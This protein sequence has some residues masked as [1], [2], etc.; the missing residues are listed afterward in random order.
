MARYFDGASSISL[1]DNAALSF[2]SDVDND[3]PFSFAFWILYKP[4]A[5]SGSQF[6]VGW[7]DWQAT[8]S[9]NIITY[10]AAGASPGRL[11]I[12]IE[13]GN[14]SNCSL[15]TNTAMNDGAWHH[16]AI[17]FDGTVLRAYIDGTVET[18]TTTKADLDRVDVGGTWHFGVRSLGYNYLQTT[19]MAEWAKWDVALTAEEIARLVAGVRAVDIGRRPAWY[20]PMCGGLHEEIG[21]V[22]ATNSGTDESE[23]PPRAVCPDRP[24]VSRAMYALIAGPYQVS[25]AE[26]AASG[27]AS[28]QVF[29][30]GITVGQVNE[31]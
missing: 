13:G 4:N 18:T 11:L 3:G 6:V 20:V 2:G 31:Q 16:A 25:A 26:S 12:N 22:A 14:G 1:A 10:G 28:A 24:R 19:C 5:V 23:H 17:V 15:L 7:G 21:A 9:F 8:P 30:T 27:S 29:S